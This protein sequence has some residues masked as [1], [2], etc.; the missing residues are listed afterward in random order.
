MAAAGDSLPALCLASFDANVRMS[1]AGLPAGICM[2]NP[3]LLDVARVRCPDELVD[4]TWFQR[5]D[6]PAGYAFNPDS[7]RPQGFPNRK[8]EPGSSALTVNQQ[9][10]T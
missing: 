4:L 9:P 2:Y 1:G 6:D 10:L 7:P 8:A 5:A 3:T